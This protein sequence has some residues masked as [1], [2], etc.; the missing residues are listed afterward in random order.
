MNIVDFLIT[1]GANVND[2]D[3]DGVTP[4]HCASCRG[5]QHTLL[6][7]LHAN[8]DPNV[9]DSRGNTAL[10]L[11]ADHGHEDCVKAILY[12][13]EQMRMPLDT[14]PANINMDTPLHHASKWGYTGIVEILLEHGAD[15]KAR[16]RRGLTPMSI[17]H[18]TQVCRLLESG[19][20]NGRYKA[21]IAKP[22]SEHKPPQSPSIT[23][24]AKSEK[25]NTPESKV[26]VEK[27]QQADKLVAAVA[28]GDIR[29]V[30]Y[31]LGLEGPRTV[32]RDR[33][34]EELCHPLCICERCSPSESTSERNQKLPFVNINT[35]NSQGVAALHVASS[36]GF[37]EIVSL[38]LDAGANVNLATEP[39]QQTALHLACAAERI[40]IVKLLLACRNCSLDATDC[41]GDTPLHLITR[42]RN[43]RLLELLVRHG[44]NTK[45]RNTKGLTPLDEGH[46]LEEWTS[47]NIFALSSTSVSRVLKGDDNLIES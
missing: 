36:K 34:S 20:S 33:N 12:F 46:S 37:S 3:C 15:I 9:A 13:T 6:L 41:V 4:L 30:C 29:L 19:T 27:R 14:S 25:S 35:L 16:N 39:Q 45:I 42:N 24:S 11:S 28:E 31:Y 1:N 40:D 22:S 17:A 47:N 18:N 10:H 5:Y 7:L 43:L 26:S 32:V 21:V 2:A 44:A 38:L 8:A 23:S